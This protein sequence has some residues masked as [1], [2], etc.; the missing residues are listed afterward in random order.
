MAQPRT[1][2]KSVRISVYRRLFTGQIYDI[3]SNFNQ[4]V[5]YRNTYILSDL[6]YKLTHSMELLW[7]S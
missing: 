2:V 4:E 6:F 3:L 7:N 5:I 1:H